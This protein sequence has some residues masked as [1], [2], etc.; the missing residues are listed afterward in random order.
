MP[1]AVGQLPH[2]LQP[3]LGHGTIELVPQVHVRRGELHC[4][5]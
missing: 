4:V 1:G 2:R 5:A 3:R